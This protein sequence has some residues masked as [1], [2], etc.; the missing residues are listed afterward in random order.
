MDWVPLPVPQGELLQSIVW[1]GELCVSCEI[2]V[3]KWSFHSEFQLESLGLCRHNLSQWPH[4]E[5]QLKVMFMTTRAWILLSP[6]PSFSIWG[7]KVRALCCLF[8]IT[9]GKELWTKGPG[10]LFSPLRFPD[11]S[12]Y[13]N[14][15]IK[16]GFHSSISFFW[17]VLSNMIATIHLWSFKLLK[18][19][20]NKNALLLSLIT[21]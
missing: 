11:P 7:E 14:Q 10:F 20:V 13:H 4:E 18:I 9:W 5:E 16:N 12:G 21:N 8:S 2:L 15:R 3:S 17:A 19:K 6:C 1:P